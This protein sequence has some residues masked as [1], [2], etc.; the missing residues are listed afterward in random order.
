MLHLHLDAQIIDG[1]FTASYYCTNSKVHLSLLDQ[2]KEVTVTRFTS[3]L[4]ICAIIVKWCRSAAVATKNR[5][6]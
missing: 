6:R 4:R 1:L 2:K 5:S 3:V